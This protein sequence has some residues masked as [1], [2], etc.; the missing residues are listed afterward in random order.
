MRDRANDLAILQNRAAAHS[1][2]HAAGLRKKL[3]VRHAQQQISRAAGR[4]IDF[5][6]LNIILAC[7]IA[8]NGGQDRRPAGLDLILLCNR[9][10]RAGDLCRVLL[11]AAIIYGELKDNLKIFL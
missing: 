9:Q 7:F 6:D 10:R 8:G 3:L 11:Y 1:L 4:R 5:F 2:H